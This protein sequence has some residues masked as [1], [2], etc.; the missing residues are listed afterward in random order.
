[1]AR[2]VIANL[3]AGK[4]EPPIDLIEHIA[5]ALGKRLRDFAEE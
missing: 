4:M 3:E 1:V 5:I 2:E